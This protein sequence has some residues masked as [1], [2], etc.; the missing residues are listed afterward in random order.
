[1]NRWTKRLMLQTAYCALGIVAVI[2]SF[3]LF[4]YQYYLNWYIFFT[5][6]SNY[7]CV[8]VVALQL[9]ETLKNP[10][11]E[12]NQ[13]HSQLTVLGAVYITVTMLI[14][15]AVIAHGAGRD[16]AKNWT[17]EC[18]LLHSVLP[19]LY[20]W[21][22]GC[23]YRPGAAAKRMPI[24]CLI[25]PTAYVV[26]IL[27]RAQLVAEQAIAKGVKKFPYFFMDIDKQGIGKTIMWMAIVFGT[28]FLVGCAV[29]VVDRYRAKKAR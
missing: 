21:N 25:V 11:E 19:V 7:F 18:V 17:V 8:G 16:P 5:N 15:H 20:L 14:F 24:Q 29:Y 10:G 26:F 9:R 2:A 27:V 6:L 12:Y 13:E 1:M 4:E 23:S 28:F 3:G 22:W